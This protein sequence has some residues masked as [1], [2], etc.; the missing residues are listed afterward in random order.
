MPGDIK[1]TVYQKIEWDII[2]WPRKNNLKVLFF[3]NLERKKLA[4]CVY[5]EYAKRRKKC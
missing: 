3:R 1:G 2:Y 4:L 5:G